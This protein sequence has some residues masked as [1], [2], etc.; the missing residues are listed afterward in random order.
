MSEANIKAYIDFPTR[1]HVF[2]ALDGCVQTDLKK[3]AFVTSVSGAGRTALL[4]AWS[5]HARHLN[6]TVMIE[7]VPQP[8]PSVPMMCVTFS[9]IW[10]ELCRRYYATEG[11]LASATVQKPFLDTPKS[12]FTVRQALSLF[13]E[14]ILPLLD[15]LQITTI[16]IDNASLLDQPALAWV[17]KARLPSDPWQRNMPR[18]AL[19]FGARLNPHPSTKNP[20]VAMIQKHP[21]LLLPW[22]KRLTLDMLTIHE[23]FHMWAQALEVNLRAQ[24]DED[25]GKDERKQMIAN[26]W[27][28]T[29]GNWWGIEALIETYHDVLGPFRGRPYRIITREVIQ[30]VQEHFACVQW[31]TEEEEEL[32]P[33][34]RHKER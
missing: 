21:N 28:K 19:I 34:K 17:L 15:Y 29:S 27:Q 3:V 12:W 8:H 32:S 14:H 26:D 24:F 6:N 33:R 25:I 7:L 2:E 18:R 30:R 4:E 11:F 31:T 5:K 13:H 10:H 1:A 16:V 9:L 20:F 23:F 22:E